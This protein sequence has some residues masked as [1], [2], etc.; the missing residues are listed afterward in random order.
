MHNPIAVL[1]QN[2]I[3]TKSAL[4]AV[5]EVGLLDWTSGDQYRNAINELVGDVSDYGSFD[6]LTAKYVYKYLVQ[7]LVKA[8]NSGTPFNSEAIIVESVT[9][10]QKMVSRLRGGD[11]SYMLHLADNEL[12]EHDVPA[13]KVEVVVKEHTPRTPRNSG[14]SKKERAIDLYKAN[15]N[16]SRDELVTLFMK[17]L[18]M[19]KAGATTYVYLC[20]KEVA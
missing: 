5:Q 3:N 2:K 18:D 12:L 1:E 14:P 19:T 9:S 16:L 4:L 15:R 20:K 13:E 10:A 6:S 8:H 7:N 17:E 11:L